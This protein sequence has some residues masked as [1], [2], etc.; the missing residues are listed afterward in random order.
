MRSGTA[1]G[2]VGTLVP[3]YFHPAVAPGGWRRLAD[4]GPHSVVLNVASGPGEVPDPVFQRAVQAVRDA[5][6]T[7]TA[8]VD[9][10]YAR[11][12]PALVEEDLRRYRAWYG[13]SDVFFDQAPA[14]PDALPYLRAVTESARVSGA[15]LVVLNHGTHP[16]PGYLALADV[17]VTFE[18]PASA[19]LS[20][21]PP[22]W[23]RAHPR[24]RF[25]HLVH[26]CPSGT[27]L[28][29]LTRARDRAGLL[30][31][32]DRSLPNP[33]DRLPPHF[34]H[35]LPSGVRWGGWS[36]EADG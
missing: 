15:A 21:T 17:L 10:S 16:D 12:D 24:H 14:A 31:V 25:C 34:P 18:G 27:L 33:Y 7:V 19:Y 23:T 32:T 35:L 8:Y 26:T 13:V 4:P 29:V 1:E 11:R 9:V 20:L 22:S 28:R 2:A 3:A 36:A 30:Y 5:G 6:G